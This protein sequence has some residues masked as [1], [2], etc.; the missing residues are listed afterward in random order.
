MRLT[1]VGDWIKYVTESGK[2]FFYNVVTNDFQWDDPTGTGH[3]RDGSGKVVAANAAGTATTSDKS[4]SGKNAGNT[5]G[6]NDNAESGAT[7][8]PWRPYL[9]EETDTVFWYNSVTQVSQ[10]ECPFDNPTAAVGASLSPS[11]EDEE[12]HGQKRRSSLGSVDEFEGDNAVF[13]VNHENDLDL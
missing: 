4:N 2:I 10:W 6:D 5:G 7:G 8:N 3:A 9:D 1:K 11:F 12:R 13:K